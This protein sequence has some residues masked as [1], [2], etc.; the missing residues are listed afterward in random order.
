[1]FNKCHFKKSII[2]PMGWLSGDMPQDSVLN[3][4]Q[5]MSSSVK[6]MKTE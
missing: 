1:M 2:N 6:L 3:A 4:D 5:F